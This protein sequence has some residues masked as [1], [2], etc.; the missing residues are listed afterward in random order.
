MGTAL[1]LVTLLKHIAEKS[2]VPNQN[3]AIFQIS[4]ILDLRADVGAH[5]LSKIT[6]EHQ[7]WEKALS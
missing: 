1:H 4:G 5:R 2:P 7:M 6:D 3:D